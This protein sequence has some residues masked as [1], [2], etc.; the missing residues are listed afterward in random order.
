MAFVR[1]SFSNIIEIIEFWK[2][3]E[4]WKILYDLYLGTA[5]LCEFRFPFRFPTTLKISSYDGG[6]SS[7][8]FTALKLG[9]STTDGTIIIRPKCMGP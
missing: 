8:T 1:V 4:F 6:H 7:T 2:I 9:L 5:W 3:V